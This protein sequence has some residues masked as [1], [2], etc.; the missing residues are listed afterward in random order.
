MP[1]MKPIAVEPAVKPAVERP[2]PAP[3]HKNIPIKET[4]KESAPAV[5]AK[6]KT[7][8]KCLLN[9]NTYDVVS[10]VA[11]GDNI[12]CHLA[13]DSSGYL[14]LGYYGNNLNIIKQYK[15]LKSEKIQAR[16]SEKTADGSLRYIIR[17]GMAKFIADVKDNCINYVM[18]L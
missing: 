2:R 13:K 10:S 18:D 9:G 6:T 15:M 16:L 7:D 4:P 12:G 14:V 5:S 3:V 1:K 8:I 11:L 17:I